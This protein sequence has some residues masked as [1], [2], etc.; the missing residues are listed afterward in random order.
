MSR[1]TVRQ[2]VTNP[3]KICHGVRTFFSEHFD[4]NHVAR[5]GRSQQEATNDEATQY[6]LFSRHFLGRVVA[7]RPRPI[8][9]A[10]PNG[11]WLSAVDIQASCSIPL[12]RS[13]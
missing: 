9:L 7:T 10:E 6:K 5:E 2:K 4:N 1:E 12:R 13:L 3:N 8:V 11:H